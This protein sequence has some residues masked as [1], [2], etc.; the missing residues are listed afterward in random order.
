MR[1]G[2]A[3]VAGILLL[4]G[5]G[6]A[7]YLVL[8]K[9]DEV[10]YS[11]NGDELDCEEAGALS[12]TEYEE[13]IAAERAAQRRADACEE[14]VGH[15]LADTQELDSRLTVGLTYD[16]YNRQVGNISVAYNQI[17][18]SSLRGPCLFD[19]AVHLEEAMNSYI[20]A[21][22]LWNECLVD[23]GCRSNSIDPQ[24]Q[25]HWAE[26]ASNINVAQRGLDGLA[27]PNG[28]SPAL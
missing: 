25:K 18:V 14:Q 12:E 28:S 23:F 2:L 3:I 16:Q 11:D 4:A 9:S 1:K 19:V 27:E 17:E 26:A 6:V 24:L 22:D 10:C 21:D 8:I 7:A 20:K 5:A 13:Q 15:I